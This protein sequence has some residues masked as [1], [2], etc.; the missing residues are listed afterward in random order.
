VSDV[1]QEQSELDRL[2]QREGRLATDWDKLD[3]QYHTALYAAGFN[4]AKMP[5]Y[6][7]DERRRLAKELAWARYNLGVQEFAMGL[8]QLKPLRPDCKTVEEERRRE[9]MGQ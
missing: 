1:A 4:L 5:S 9:G 2:S 8:R 7:V 6:L 3:S